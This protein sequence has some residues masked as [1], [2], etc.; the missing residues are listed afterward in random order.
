MATVVFYV[1]CA[2]GAFVCQVLPVMWL[3]HSLVCAVL[4][5]SS[6]CMVALHATAY[7]QDPGYTPVRDAGG[8]QEGSRR[9]VWRS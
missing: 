5:C 1:C 8:F 3:G 9:F 6:I 4:L 7:L 2:A